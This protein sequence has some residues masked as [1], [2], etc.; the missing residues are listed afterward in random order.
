M[1]D[2]PVTPVVPGDNPVTPVTPAAEAFAW[3]SQLPSDLANAATMQKFPDTKEGFAEAVK[4]HLSLEKLL[5]H[6]KVPVPKGP[7]DTVAMGLFRKAM[8][9]PEKA[10]GYGLADI[11]MPE[12][13]KNVAF[14]KGKFAEIVHKHD[15]TPTQAKGLWEAYTSMVGQSYEGAVKSQKEMLTGIINGLRA[16]WGDAYEGHVELG[17]TVINKFSDDKEMN[18]FITASL[19]KDPRGIKFLAKLGEQF[20]ENKIPGFENKRFSQTPEEAQ[21]EWDAVKRDPNHPYN[22]AKAPQAERDRAIAYVN[23]LIATVNK[24]KKG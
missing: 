19:T 23:G 14:D 21:K 9:I 6:E 15:L 2:N 5:G 11:K 7:D 4:S 17:Q 12:S 3:K 22:N 10:D 24:G 13:M 8:G 16:E 1:P 20:A 18:D